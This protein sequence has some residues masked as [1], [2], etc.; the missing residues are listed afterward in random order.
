M[1][2]DLAASRGCESCET[3][4][5][6][7]S[8]L[9]FCAGEKREEEGGGCGDK[10]AEEGHAEGSAAVCRRACSCCVGRGDRGGAAL[11]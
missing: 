8:V 11:L 4:H 2:C 7:E 3:S 9:I 6:T 10:R 1:L 5:L